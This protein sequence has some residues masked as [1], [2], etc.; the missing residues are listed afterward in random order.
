MKKIVVLG[1]ITL[2]SLLIA[3]GC[4]RTVMDLNYEFNKANIKLQ[5]GEVISIN[6]KSW[7][8]YE[9]EQLQIIA[10]DGT[11]YLVSSINCDLIKIK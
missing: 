6:V 5:T 3:T 10:E 2:S 8:D 9:G 11:V 4:N 1:I 7:K